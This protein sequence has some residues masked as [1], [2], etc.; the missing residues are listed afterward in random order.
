MSSHRI[1]LTRA[2]ALTLLRAVLVPVFA[3]AILAGNWGLAALVFWAAVATDVADGRVARRYGEVTELGALIDHSADALFVS[4]GAAALASV[5]ALPIALA[6]LIVLA[7]L[8]YAVDSRMSG[9]R[10][11]RASRLGRWN[12]VAYYVAIAIPV[13]R[14]ALGFDWPGASLVFWFGWALVGSTALS[15]ASRLRALFAAE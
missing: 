10:G 4:V 11:L 15:M 2:N 6:P 9:H 7:F 5:G 14:D 13:M 3:L 12:G 8:Q 1:R